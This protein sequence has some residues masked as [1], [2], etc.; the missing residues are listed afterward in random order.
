V[1]DPSNGSFD[2]APETDRDDDLRLARKIP[3]RRDI[4]MVPVTVADEDCRQISEL[5]AGHGRH[6]TSDRA[7]RHMAEQRI[8]KHAHALEVDEDGR[9]AEERQSI[10]QIDASETTRQHATCRL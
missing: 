10:A 3:Q 7:G 4:Q 9:M 5:I 8:G 6:L 1:D 2:E